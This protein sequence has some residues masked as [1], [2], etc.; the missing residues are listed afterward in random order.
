METVLYGKERRKETIVKMQY[1]PGTITFIQT[2]RTV[3]VIS[4][5]LTEAIPSVIFGLQATGRAKA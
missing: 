5:S 3:K 4:F 2:L 1:L